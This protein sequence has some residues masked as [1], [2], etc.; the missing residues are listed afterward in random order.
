MHD[1]RAILT[2]EPVKVEY[3]GVQLQLKR[4]TLLDLVEAHEANALG[5]AQSRAWALWRH[6]QTAEGAQVW[7]SPEAALACPSGL[8]SFLVTKIEALYSEGVD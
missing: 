4:P 8:A 5:A 6:V 7:A 3:H 2:L 1:L